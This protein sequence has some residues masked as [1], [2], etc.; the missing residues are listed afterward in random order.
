[1]SSVGFTTYAV[2]DPTV[3]RDRRLAIASLPLVAPFFISP[4]AHR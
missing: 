3:D 4:E 1:M 2:L